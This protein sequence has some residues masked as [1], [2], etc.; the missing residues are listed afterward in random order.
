MISSRIYICHNFLQH[1]TESVQV[2]KLHSVEKHPF[3]CL[4]VKKNN[5]LQ[6]S[7]HCAS[8]WFEMPSVDVT[9]AAALCNILI[10]NKNKVNLSTPSIRVNR[11]WSIT[12]SI[13]AIST[14]A[15]QVI[16]DILISKT[17]VSFHLIF[18]TDRYR[19]WKTSPLGQAVSTLKLKQRFAFPARKILHI[20]LYKPE[21]FWASLLRWT[22]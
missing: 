3:M 6:L 19:D 22:A 15:K 17:V 7:F 8:I 12:V 4:K 10:K 1:S 14:S 11:A 16:M 18:T 20:F 2:V 5:L 21:Q 9:K 13:T